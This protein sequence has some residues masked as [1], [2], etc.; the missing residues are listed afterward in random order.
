MLQRSQ[1]TVYIL[2]PEVTRLQQLH[3][4]WDAKNKAERILSKSIAEQTKPSMKQEESRSSPGYSRYY[5][6]DRFGIIDVIRIRIGITIVDEIHG[7]HVLLSGIGFWRNF[8]TTG[9]RRERNLTCSLA[10]LVKERHRPED[11][12]REFRDPGRETCTRESWPINVPVFEIQFYFRTHDSFMKVRKTQ[13]REKQEWLRWIQ[14][15]HL[16]E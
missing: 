6:I 15:G 14:I 13:T 7:D 3:I 8:D 16:I 5:I 1:R 9:V 12:T 11:S 4:G 10:S 2:F